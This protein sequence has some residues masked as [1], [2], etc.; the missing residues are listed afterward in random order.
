MPRFDEDLTFRETYGVDEDG[1]VPGWSDFEAEAPKGYGSPG[2][3]SARFN[4]NRR[5]PL[6]RQIENISFDQKVS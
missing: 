5:N 1:R 6:S 4:A 3:A 2:R